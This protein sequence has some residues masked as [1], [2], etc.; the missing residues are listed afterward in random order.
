MVFPRSINGLD[1]WIEPTV[2]NSSK[3]LDILVD[4]VFGSFGIALDDLSERD[5]VVQLGYPPIRVDLMNDIS[6]LKF[7][8]VYLAHH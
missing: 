8:H 6:G 4:F 1:I 5:K 7:E 3:L 2:R